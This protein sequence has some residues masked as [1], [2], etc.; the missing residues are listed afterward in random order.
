MTNNDASQIEVSVI[1]PVYNASKTIDRCVNSLV[2]QQTRWPYEVLLI[3][4][5]STDDSLERLRTWERSNGRI[6]VFSQPNSGVSIARNVGLKAAKGRY[7]MF[8][9]SDDW[10]GPSY[11]EHLRNS[12]IDGKRGV[13]LAGYVRES[14]KGLEV[15]SRAP[16][17][18]YPCD[19]HIVIDSCRLCKQGYPWAKIYA[20][21]GTKELFFEPT[22]QFSEDMIFFL[23]YLKTADY[24]RFI[25]EADYHYM[26][27][28]SGSLIT[29][30]N[31]FE[32]EATGYHAFRKHI[33]DLQRLY[34]ITDDELKVT[35]DHLVYFMMRAIRTMYRNGKHYLRR[36]DRVQRLVESFDDDD[37]ALAYR[38]TRSVKGIDN[39]IGY[40]M[41]RREYRLLDALLWLFFRWRCSSLGNIC[42][43]WYL[44]TKG[45]RG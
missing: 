28:E 17:I 24:I 43:K 34:C 3:D 16:R 18:L 6:R 4:D 20:L 32:S 12:V 42:V 15:K 13:T 21:S 25:G 9:D 23:E 41:M 40:F 33:I 14:S 5:G 27:K 36:R 10:A 7:V 35:L 44:R 38:L 19:Y 30:Y 45:V 37:R 26:H 1:V 31:S 39:M 29:R 22:V 2:D 11:I 8:V